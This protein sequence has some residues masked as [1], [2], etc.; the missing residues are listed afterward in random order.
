MASLQEKIAGAILTVIRRRRTERSSTGGD[1]VEPTRAIAPAKVREARFSDFEAVSALKQRWSM[2]A[3]SLENWERLWH[4]NPALLC[5]EVKRPIGWVLEADGAIVGYMGNISLQCW[6]GEKA[7]AAVASHGLVVDTPY[8]AMSVTL[9]APFYRQKSVDLYLAT[10]AMEAVGKLARA[11]KC[12]PLPQAEYDSVLF[13][14]LQPYPFARSLMRKLDLGSASAWVGS[15]FTAI[16]VGGDRALRGRRPGRS[17]RPFTITDIAPRDMGDDFQSLWTAKLNEC[18]RLFADR[19]PAALRWHFE[20]PG[21]RGCARVLCCHE[22]GKLVGY[23]VIRTDTDQETGL[24]KS[25]I[26][27]TL[28]RQDE[29]EIVRALWAAA[30][31]NA[32]LAGS[33]V[34]EVMGFPST[35]RK[36]CTEWNP[37]VRKY[38]ACPYYYKAADPALQAALA[39]GAAWYAT[40]YDGDATLIRPSYSSRALHRPPGVKMEN[41]TDRIL[42]HVSE[43]QRT[44]VF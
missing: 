24:R 41:D 36:V 13:W 31:E 19:S 30:Y 43:E 34:L 4:G 11:L 35:L 25:I 18:T 42:P 28:V 44:E 37:Y 32:K 38:P 5:G 8:R 22:D 20:I 15:V 17:A 39:D 14:V 9:V 6:Y 29:P 26:A 10:S 1:H 21:D 23:A 40:P 33:D 3:D 7:L 16:A 12:S 27:D 2:D